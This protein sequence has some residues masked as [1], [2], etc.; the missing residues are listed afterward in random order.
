MSEKALFPMQTLRVTQGYYTNYSHKQS[1]ALDLGGKDGGSDPVYAPFSGTIKRI[2]STNGEMWLESDAPVEWADGTVDY[3][4]VLFIHA[5]SIPVSVNQHVVQGQHIYNEGNKGNVTGTHLHIECARGKFQAPYGYYNTGVKWTSGGATYDVWEIYNQVKVHDALFVGNDVTIAEPGTDGSTGQIINWVRASTTT[6]GSSL[7]DNTFFKVTATNLQFMHT[8]DVNDVCDDITYNGYL[9]QGETYR[10]YEKTT[11]GGFTWWKFRY[12]NGELY[13]CAMVDGR[14]TTEEA[15][16]DSSRNLTL[17]AKDIQ[18]EVYNSID[19]YDKQDENLSPNT[20]VTVIGV[21][22]K[23]WFGSL[24]YKYSNGSK[25]LYVPHSENITITEGVS[26]WES[27][28]PDWGI[29]TLVGNVEYFNS[30]DVYDIAPDQ[31]LKL[32]AQYTAI[33]RSTEMINGFYW[34]KIIYTDDKEYYVTNESAKIVLG[35]KTAGPSGDYTDNENGIDVSKYQGNINWAGVKSDSKGYKFAFIR[36]VSTT[37]MSLTVDPYFVQNVQNAQAQGIATGAYIYT[38]A[39]T[40]SYADQEIDLCIQQLRS[41]KWGYPIAWDCEDNSLPERLT[42]TQLTD[43][44]LYALR[45]IRSYGYYPILYSYTNFANNYI[46]M[47]RIYEAGFD[48]W[49][50]D[51]RG[52]CGYK[53]EYKIW[54]HSSTTAVNGISGNCDANISYWDYPRYIQDLG[55]NGYEGGGSG[56][57]YP[58]EPMTGYHMEFYKGNVQYFSYPSIYDENWGYFPQG[59]ATPITAKLLD[60]YDGFPFYTC[61]YNGNTVYVGYV[62]D[63]RMAIV[64]DEPSEYDVPY[65]HTIYKEKNFILEDRNGHTQTFGSPDVND[66]DN[67]YLGRYKTCRLYALLNDKYGDFYFYAAVVEDQIRYIALETNPEKYVTYY[68]TPYERTEVTDGSTFQVVGSGAYATSYPYVEAEHT[69]LTVGNVYTIASKLNY[70]YSGLDWYVIN[71][72]GIYLYAPVIDGVVNVGQVIGYTELPV[73]SYLRISVATDQGYVYSI[74]NTASLSKKIDQGTLL[75]P[76]SVLEG[77][78][79]EMTWYTVMI[80][81]QK[82]YLPIDQNV[83]LQYQYD[84]V[85]CDPKFIATIVGTVNSYDHASLSAKTKSLSGEIILRSRISNTIEGKTWYTFQEEDGS[86]RYVY[87]DPENVTYHYR[88]NTASIPENSN[89]KS[90]DDQFQIYDHIPGNLETTTAIATTVPKDTI[91]P[92]SSKVQD[93][94][95]V[96]LWYVCTYQD[97]TY[98]CQDLANSDIVYIYDELTVDSHLFISAKIDNVKAYLYADKNCPG[99]SILPIDEEY[100]PEAY[101]E[102]VSSVNWYKITYNDTVMYVC[103]DSRELKKTMRYTEEDAVEGSFVLAKSNAFG[104]RYPGATLEEDRYLL[105]PG[106]RYEATRIITEEVDGRPWYQIKFSNTFSIAN[107]DFEADIGEIIDELPDDPDVE[108]PFDEIFGAL[109]TKDEILIYCPIDDLHELVYW[110]PNTECDPDTYLEVLTDNFYYFNSPVSEEGKELLPIG[111][112][113]A[114]E[115]LNQ[116]YG[117]KIWFVIDYNGEEVF[118][119]IIEDQSRIVVDGSQEKIIQKMKEIM[120]ELKGIRQEIDDTIPVAINVATSIMKSKTRLRTLE[121]RLYT[122]QLYYWYFFSEGGDKPKPI[123]YDHI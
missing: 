22:E 104:Y 6:S 75:T 29:Q 66:A 119:P 76:T 39:V 13:W 24:W 114:K 122:L 63:G 59:S 99:F 1:F 67:N 94:A 19:L 102:N 80:D 5:N 103:D 43:M 73:D 47:T 42:K 86:T 36:C 45:R 68:G 8:P 30:P 3:M 109:R 112:Y 79:Q 98:Y 90:L 116:Q 107:I 78:Y 91:L 37:G 16:F 38:Y 18:V 72:D 108:F 100:K 52:Y 69:D 27:L 64:K 101:V 60:E 117:E 85:I 9:T 32:G 49:C 55:L 121:L 106:K 2:R 70:Q 88:Y 51:Y 83:S 110:Y 25:I 54:Q 95:I 87:E 35:P 11:A 105:D 31:Y 97:K 77:T 82:W 14:Y 89:M 58:S 23:E 118:A 62:D 113:S 71:V 46:D 17:T 74:A 10:A 26:I 50:A 123:T 56:T 96:G 15:T 115:K 53:G 61:T 84:F 93:D 40:T 21:T 120:T 12:S 81:D 20:S 44:V 41:Y 57:I 111:R 7:P 34:I 92:V 65:V 33:Q 48:F 28:P 4:T